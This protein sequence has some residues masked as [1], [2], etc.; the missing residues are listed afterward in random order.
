MTKEKN[1]VVEFKEVLRN[2]VLKSSID[3]EELSKFDFYNITFEEA[4][5]LNLLIEWE[6]FYYE[7]KINIA[8]HLWSR[9]K[10]TNVDK[11]LESKGYNH[12]TVTLNLML[13]IANDLHEYGYKYGDLEEY[14]DQ[15]NTR[16]CLKRK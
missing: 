16:H 11:Y 8:S 15:V 14:K 2:E 4:K 12:N 9:R 7:Y 13:E 10:D 1:I 3:I 5:E 6:L